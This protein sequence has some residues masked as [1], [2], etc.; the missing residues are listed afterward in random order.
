MKYHFY[1]LKNRKK[2]E[3]EVVA[4][5]SYGDNKLRYALKGKTEDGRVMTTFVS[6]SVYEKITVGE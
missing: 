5:Q 6:K 3:L 2:V 4:K 1:D